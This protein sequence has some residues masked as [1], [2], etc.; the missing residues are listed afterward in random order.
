MNPRRRVWV[1]LA[2][3][4]SLVLVAGVAWWA[5][6]ATFRPP[7][8]LDEALPPP[9]YT[10]TQAS[11]G[12]SLPVMVSVTWP[13]RSLAAGSLSG[14][15]TAIDLP[16]SG[17]IETGDVLLSVNLRP[18]VVMPGS[19]PAFRDLGVGMTG[20]DVRQLQDYLRAAGYLATAPDGKFQAA[21]AAAVRAWQAAL[22]LE[23][24]GLV[25][26]GDVLFVA[27]LPARVVLDDAVA[28][29]AVISPGQPILSVVDDAPV[30]QVAMTS[31]TGSSLV[32]RSGQSASVSSPDG[33]VVWDAAVAQVRAE[34]LGGYTAVLT[35]PPGGPVCADQCDV[36]KYAPDGLI[37]SG[38]LVVSPEVTGPA[39]PLAA[40]G[41]ASDGSR[42][43]LREDGTRLPV[44]VLGGDASRLIVDGVAVG[45]VVQLFAEAPR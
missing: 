37:L 13:T 28:V 20:D 45:E 41:T 19:V 25:Q 6:W 12:A 22:G 40:V 33:A 10:V 8:V 9:T 2:W 26:A 36:L 23:R 15:V 32:P 14:M 17:M 21:T 30:F 11:I 1:P 3:L 29:G 39:V 38:T 34:A 4:L 43:V 44:T 5:A 7:Q 16:E 18:V 42:F 35:A 31:N 24:T 27:S